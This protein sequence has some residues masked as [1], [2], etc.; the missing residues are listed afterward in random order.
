M[1]AYIFDFTS[2]LYNILLFQL[3]LPKFLRNKGF[4][5]NML[6]ADFIRAYKK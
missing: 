6:L 3:L 4:F 5:G 2:T 1:C